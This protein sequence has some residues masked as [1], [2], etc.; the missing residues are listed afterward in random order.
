MGIQRGPYGTGFVK[1]LGNTVGYKKGNGEYGINAYQPEVI[2]PRTYPQ[3]VQ[4]VKFAFLRT[5]SAGFAG[6]AL[7]G[8]MNQP[9][10]SWPHAFMAMN[11]PYTMLKSE[12]GDP[13]IDVVVTC[14]Q[15]MLSQGY[16][17]RPFYNLNHCG[18]GVFETDICTYKNDGSMRP[19]GVIAVIGVDKK[20]GTSGYVFQVY[21]WGYIQEDGVVYSTKN[22]QV[23]ILYP[24]GDPRSDSYNVYMWFYNYRFADGKRRTLNPTVSVSAGQT[25]NSIEMQTLTDVIGTRRVFS[26]TAFCVA[27]NIP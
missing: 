14:R 9:Y 24:D 25:N 27:P 1:R 22:K 20:V 26:P 12:P 11:M 5:L 4:R 3:R 7:R 15:L 23:E 19:D 6:E 16:E 2:N 18:A 13:E 10:T 17:Q 21:D 8:L